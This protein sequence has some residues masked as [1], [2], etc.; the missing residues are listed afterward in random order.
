ME[1]WLICYTHIWDH[2]TN[3][4]HK[5]RPAFCCAPAPLVQIPIQLIHSSLR[6]LKFVST[7]LK[8]SSR[9]VVV[10]CSWSQYRNSSL[11][12]FQLMYLA[13]TINWGI[14]ATSTDSSSCSERIKTCSNI[15]SQLCSL[16]L[17]QDRE[18]LCPQHLSWTDKP[19]KVSKH[20]RSTL[21]LLKPINNKG[22]F[23]KCT[24][25]CQE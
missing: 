15:S 22:H 21:M 3:S 2:S 14:P 6:A 9:L 23:E 13:K 17:T 5:T 4:S 11:I 20:S 16:P 8:I 25:C 19:N 1:T 12:S 18:Q 7:I 24:F 10:V